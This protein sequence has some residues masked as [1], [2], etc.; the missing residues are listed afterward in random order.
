MIDFAVNQRLIR[1]SYSRKYKLIVK[2]I[3]KKF[4]K[5]KYKILKIQAKN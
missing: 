2:I 4:T 1:P 3:G 5:Y